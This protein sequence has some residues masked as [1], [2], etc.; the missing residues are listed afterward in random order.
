MKANPFND[1]DVEEPQDFSKLLANIIISNNQVIK[2]SIN[3]EAVNL[4]ATDKMN[5][6]RN[7]TLKEK[8]DFYLKNRIDDQYQWYVR[9]A[10][11]NGKNYILYLLIGAVLQCFVIS[12]AIFYYFC[13]SYNLFLFTQPALVLVAGIIGWMKVRKYKE[14]ASSYGLTAHEISII[15]AEYKETADESVFTK[16]VDK[17]EHVFSREHTQWVALGKG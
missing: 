2:S 7:Y 12:F 11:K 6:I 9:K 1:V 15:R 5:E 16:F 17:V 14:L 13:F 3:M 4:N 10:D 8:Q